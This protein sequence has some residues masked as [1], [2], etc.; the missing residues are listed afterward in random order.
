[1]NLL[2]ILHTHT[3]RRKSSFL[4]LPSYRFL[5]S[6]FLFFPI[7]FCSVRSMGSLP[8]N[9]PSLSSSAADDAHDEPPLLYINGKR[10]ILPRHLAHQTLLEFLR[11][12]AK[13]TNYTHKP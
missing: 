11:G 3:D 4:S 8:P 12:K 13:K 7:F 6:V 5:D 10:K 2:Y 9:P 1:M